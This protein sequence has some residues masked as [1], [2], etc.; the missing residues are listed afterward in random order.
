MLPYLL[1]EPIQF[2]QLQEKQANAITWTVASLIRGAE[3][4]TAYCALIWE[5][6]NGNTKH[7]DT[8]TVEI[9][10]TTLN[11]WG[12]DDTVIDDTVLAYSPLFIRRNS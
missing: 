2:G 10:H 9:D 8:F 11:N 6:G 3:S 12:A 4:A 1:I 5:D 7:V